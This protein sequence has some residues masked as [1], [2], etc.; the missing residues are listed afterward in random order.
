MLDDDVVF[1]IVV[2]VYFI[3]DMLLFYFVYHI[4]DLK[5]KFFK[6]NKILEVIRIFNKNI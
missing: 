2:Y 6:N 4:N 1:Q 3:I 5:F